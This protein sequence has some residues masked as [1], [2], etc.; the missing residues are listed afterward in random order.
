VIAT[1]VGNGGN[2]PGHWAWMLEVG[3]LTG[4]FD[5]LRNISGGGGFSNP[6]R[7]R[8]KDPSASVPVP[9]SIALSGVFYVNHR[10][11]REHATHIYCG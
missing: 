9:A 10:G 6:Q 8:S 2:N 5:Y 7:W 3:D 1:H 4:T 11:T